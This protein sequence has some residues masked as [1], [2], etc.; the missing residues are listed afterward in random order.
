MRL[1]LL[2]LIFALCKSSTGRLTPK[3][4]YQL[5]RNAIKSVSIFGTCSLLSVTAPIVCYGLS[6]APYGLQKG[7]LL[8]CEA[9]SNCVS[10]SSIKSLDKYGLPWEYDQESDFQF[11]ALVKAVGKDPYMKIIEQDS[12]N[13]YLHAQAKSSFPPTG[14]DDVEFL[15]NTQDKLVTYRSNSRDALKAG[16]TV[17]GDGGAN[18]NRLESV[19]QRLGLREMGAEADEEAYLLEAGQKRQRSLLEQLLA[20][21]QP[22]EI[23]FVDNSVPDQD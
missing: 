8:P 11:D 14:I 9:R 22:S 19:R 18:R 6:T 3:Y 7:R 20:A 1:V 13:F 23:N 15:L 12:S 4:N 21:S 16:G 17:V 5:I 10:T 2:I